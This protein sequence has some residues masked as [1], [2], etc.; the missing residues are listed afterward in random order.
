MENIKESVL[1]LDDNLTNL[2]LFFE[3]FKNNYDITTESSPLKALEQLASKH[4]KVILV[5]YVMPEMT[6]LEFIERAVKIIP[7][8][9]YMILTAYPDLDVT[10][11]AINQGNVYRFL[12]KPWKSAEMEYTLETAF[13]KFYALKSD[14]KQVKD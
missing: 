5:D 3:V 2:T 11:R 9:I 8:G 4:Y 7:D 12:I 14:N 6:G 1:Y 13:K 10:I